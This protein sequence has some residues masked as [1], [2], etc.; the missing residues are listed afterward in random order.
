MKYCNLKIYSE[1]ITM[2]N[3][4][5]LKGSLQFG[6]LT[7]A[8]NLLFSLTFILLIY[9]WLM[10]NLTL[11]SPDFEEWY[12]SDSTSQ[13]QSVMNIFYH[14]GNIISLIPATYFAYRVSKPRRK[15][16]LKISKGLISYEDGLRLHFEKYGYSDALVF[17]AMTLAFAFLALIT[18]GGSWLGIFPLAFTLFSIFGN[19]LGPIIGF[20]LAV[21]LEYAAIP[22]GVFFAQKKWRALY[23]IGE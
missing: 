8:F 4:L 6:I 18:K 9:G 19:I 12:Y 22:V 14:I 23:F 17:A 10:P 1:D 5:D 15:E 21:A 11:F 20:I 13:L 2:K 16:F 3:K 7:V